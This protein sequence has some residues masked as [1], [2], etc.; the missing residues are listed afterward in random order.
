M[1]TLNAV[2][3]HLRPAAVKEDLELLRAV[4]PGARFVVCHG[5]SREDFEGVETDDKVFMDDP[6]L[7]GPARHLQSW[8]QAFEAIWHRYF[9]SDDSLDSL[10][11]FEFDHLILDR[12]Y[13]QRLRDLAEATRAGFMGKNCV[14]RE[15]TNWEHYVRWRRDE[16]LLAHLRSIS[17]R[18]QPTKLYGCLGDGMWLSRNA[19]RSYVAVGEHPPCYNETYVPTLLH[20]LGFRVVDVDSHSDLYSHVRFAPV[21][22]FDEVMSLAKRGGTAFVHPVKDRAANAALLRSAAS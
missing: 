1:S 21:F 15:G 19:L 5:G 3:T 18:E 20:H 9:E 13:E 11:L 4:T 14:P 6:S 2:V 22:C 17:V 16:R 8:T 10:Y 7:R 12:D